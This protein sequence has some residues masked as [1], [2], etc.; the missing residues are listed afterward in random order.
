MNAEVIAEITVTDDTRGV[1]TDMSTDWNEVQRVRRLA[2]SVYER[3]QR[4]LRAQTTTLAEV[5]ARRADVNS[6]DGGSAQKKKV[7]GDCDFR[8]HLRLHLVSQSC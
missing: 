1:A 6:G 5:K 2:S 8:Y 4:T 7:V 3:Q